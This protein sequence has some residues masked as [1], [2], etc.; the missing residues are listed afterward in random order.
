[1]LSRPSLTWMLDEQTN[2][3]RGSPAEFASLYRCHDLRGSHVIKLGT[4]RLALA[5]WP[6][7]YLNFPPNL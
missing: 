1:M 3:I 6:G 2:G 7:A 4:A 5:A